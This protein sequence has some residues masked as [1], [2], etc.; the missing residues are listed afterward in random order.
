MR[1]WAWCIWRKVNNVL[2][3]ISP[4]YAN[5]EK[6]SLLPPQHMYQGKGLRI[7]SQKLEGNVDILVKLYVRA[8]QSTEDRIWGGDIAAVRTPVCRVR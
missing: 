3:A 2:T 5:V 1:S 6:N 8:G 7:H 4:S